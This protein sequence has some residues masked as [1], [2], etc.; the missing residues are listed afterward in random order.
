M[1]SNDP[2]EE[3]TPD[4][5][6][7]L[8]KHVADPAKGR[9]FGQIVEHWQSMV[10]HS[11]YRRSGDATIAEDVVQK[12][13]TILARKARAVSRHSSPLSW[14]F[15]TTKLET[16]HAMRGA[17]RRKRKHDALSK[18]E[19]NEPSS[20]NH[21]SEL[22]S[23]LDQALDRLSD[24]D[25]ELVLLKFY[26]GRTYSEISK[27]TGRSQSANK[28]R[29]KRALEKLGE[30]LKGQGVNLSVVAIGPGMLAEFTKASPLVASKVASSSLAG[31]SSIVTSNLITNTLSTMSTVKTIS[32]ATAV[33]VVL[34]TIPFAI[35]MSTARSLDSEITSLSSQLSAA[36]AMPPPHEISST[37]ST[38]RRSIR[39]II[40]SPGKPFMAEEFITEVAGAFHS[41]DMLEILKIL[42]PIGK[43]SQSDLAQA[44]AEVRQVESSQEEK[45]VAIEMLT[46][47]VTTEGQIPELLDQLLSDESESLRYSSLMKSWAVNDPAAALAWLQAKGKDGSFI[48]KGT[49]DSP[50]VSLYNAFLS[51]LVTIDPTQAVEVLKGLSPEIK[52]DALSQFGYYLY[53]EGPDK[54]IPLISTME[55]KDRARIVRRTAN[56][57]ANDYSVDEALLWISAA[58]LPSTELIEAKVDLASDHRLFDEKGIDGR[59][60]WLVRDVGDEE[61]S[62]YVSSFARKNYQ[63]NPRSLE[64]WIDSS[65][66]NELR[67]FMID[68]LISYAST[69]RNGGQS[70]ESL[71]PMAKKVQD[72]AEREKLYEVILKSAGESLKRKEAMSRAFIDAG[73]NLP[74]N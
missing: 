18:A 10:Y 57:Y 7:L 3:T 37:S 8:R 12:V 32:T 9:A 5:S 27:T 41:R 6:E 70:M 52:N 23:T 36:E 68:G 33:V 39:S 74:T 11:A 25:R 69:S 58:D 38:P 21:M 42:V 17:Q 59:I 34:A 64:K 50:E 67:D 56:G 4:F 20:S 30:S 54:M 51:G 47:L 60:D 29:L 13:F 62:K 71:I 73:V 55:P 22:K 2:N 24:V 40:H 45:A 48:Q 31:S 43:M 14:L 26:E 35:Q 15:Q 16:L 44:I 28:M 61:L 66:A 72:P 49:R 46:Q 65:P 63:I 53:L 1:E 19:L